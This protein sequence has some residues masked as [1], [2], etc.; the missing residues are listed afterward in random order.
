MTG[1][2]G[3][4]EQAG[5]AL[6]ARQ[7]SAEELTFEHLRRIERENARLNAFLTIT[8]ESALEQARV[9]DRELTSGHDRGPLHGIPIALKDMYDTNGIRTTYGSRMFADHVPDHDAAVVERLREAG[10]VLVGKTGLHELC[11]GITSSNPHFGPVRNPADPARIPGG[12][13]GGSAAAVAAGLVLGA[14]GSDTGGSIRIPASF[15]G[16]AGIKPTFGRVSRFGVSPLG[17]SMDHM[18]PL[19]RTVRDS[20]IMLQAIAGFD[21]RDENSSRQPVPQYLPAESA[22]G[23][24]GVRVGW[25][26]Q[27]FFD[28]IDPE[29]AGAIDR[30]RE[31]AESLG[32]HI[33]PVDVPDMEAINAVARV[34]LLAEAAAAYAPYTHR[35]DHIGTDVMALF[36]QGRL[37]PAVDYVNAQRLRK[38]QQRDWAKIWE[39]CDVVFAPSTP[40]TA[41]LI[42]QQTIDIGGQPEDVRIASTRLVRGVNALGIPALALPAGVSSSGLP[43][44]MQIIGQ[45][46][47]EAELF[48]IGAALEMVPGLTRT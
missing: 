13:S 33:V 28:R 36:D 5:T 41:P 44:G 26:R 39:H 3:S 4:I 11:Y 32:G 42:G 22:T 14:M 31:H 7:I 6:R 48:R 9:L 15:C 12:S 16:C 38:R 40:T 37:L 10:A 46:F 24:Q 47:Q 27:F 17:F 43:I 35:R 19:T 1:D 21:P 25:P 18:G 8:A 30:Q 2:I 29:V 23:L 34:L 45:P 20:A